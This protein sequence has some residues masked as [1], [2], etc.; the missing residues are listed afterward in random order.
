MDSGITYP[1]NCTTALISSSY[2]AS[3]HASSTGGRAAYDGQS[4]P[5]LI[6]YAIGEGEGAV[7]ITE[8]ESIRSE[9]NVLIKV[10]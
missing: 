1:Y 9:F 4:Y 2:D 7:E 6:F 10:V 3:Y 8:D 5:S